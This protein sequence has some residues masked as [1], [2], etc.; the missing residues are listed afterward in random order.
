MTTSTMT[1]ATTRTTWVPPRAAFGQ[2]IRTEW[3]TMVRQKTVL[4]A[5]LGL[6]TVLLVIFGLIPAFHHSI[7]ALGGLTLLDVYL[8][9]VIA[10]GVMGVG[11]Y[12]LPP[13]LASY[14]ELGILR[15]LST[16]PVRPSWLLAVQLVVNLALAVVSIVIVLVLGTAAFGL[17]APKNPGGFLVAWLLSVL[18]LFTMG[19]WIGSIARTGKA[20]GLIG[21]AFFY[22]FMFFSGMWLPQGLMPAVLRDI[23]HYTSLGASVQALQSAMQGSFPPGSSLLVMAVWAIA[24][25]VA[26]VR[27]FKWE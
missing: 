19:L 10:T 26:A 11:L 5:G 16:T 15:R 21:A 3:L 12:G 14:R 13:I 7:G 1:T 24:F 23:S 18:A 25:G 20:A 22:P 2:L 17:S 27:S 9:I 4:W 8:P 6:P